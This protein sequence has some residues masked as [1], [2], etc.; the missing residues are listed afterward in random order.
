MEISKDQIVDLMMGFFKTKTLTAAFDLGLFD[1]MAEGPAS[2]ED[3]CARA[4]APVASGKRMLIALQAMGL[5]QREGDAYSLA[6]GAAPYLVS[7]SPQWLGWL[8]RHIDAFLYP[9][10]S[11]T[12]Q[13]VRDDKDQ[14]EAVFGDK[15]SWF[16][17][18]YQNPSD[19]TDFQEFL[20][21]FAK[22]FID[23]MVE[24]VDFSAYSRFMD[25]GSGVGSLPVAVAEACPHLEIAICELPKAACYVRDKIMSGDF[26]D[27]IKVVEGDVIAGTIPQQEYDLIHLGWMLHDYAP[28]TQL[29][30]LRNIYDALPSG[31]VFMASET[32]L[33]EDES[34]PL[35]TSLLS[36]NMLVS[37]DGGVESTAQQYMQRFEEAG[38]SNVRVLRIN[39]P[40][41][42]FVGEKA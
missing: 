6:P 37:T 16:D 40:R 19:V 35:F 32:P 39:G 29:Q 28:D 38:F 18:L 4:N 34:G 15:R 10:W 20:G 17:I 14:R 7:Q 36:I 5:L 42:L 11:N 25:I 24:G 23:G 13:A 26:A 1:A 2:L 21:I 8:G 3:I 27:R 22:P 30:I 9:L 12:A 41:T 33:D 31:G